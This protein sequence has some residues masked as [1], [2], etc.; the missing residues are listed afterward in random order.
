M[1]SYK[2]PYTPNAGKSPKYL[3]GRNDLLDRVQNQ[4]LAFSEGYNMQPIVYYGLRGVGKTVLLN[5]IEAVIEKHEN[6]ICHHIEIKESSNFIKSM[7]RACNSTASELSLQEAIKHIKNKLIS[8]INQFTLTWDVSAQTMSVG[9]TPNEANAITAD[10]SNDFTEILITL[11]KCAKETNNIIVF[12][13]DEIQYANTQ[14]LEAI[15]T[16]LHRV[17]QL[18]LPIMM[19]CAGLP[20]ILKTMGDVKSYAERL[21]QFISVGSLSKTEAIEAIENPARDIGVS[22]TKDALDYILDVTKGYPYFIQAVC[23]TIWENHDSNIIDKNAVMSYMNIANEALDSGFFAVRY[24]RAT[25]TERTFMIAMTQCEKTPCEI[26]AIAKIMNKKP[27]QI[28]PIRAQLIN[29]GL[30]YATRHGEI[31]FTAP[32][33]DMFIRR[34]NLE[35]FS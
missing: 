7:I 13:V 17:N 11:G 23:S 15:I 24:N 14:E 20:K 18:S 26:A 12:F 16:A 4:F 8:T 35:A 6:T 27:K 34:A 28:S 30:V 21:F 1:I 10:F 5:E 25:A 19:I 3:A 2:N 33:F 29:K 22:Y 9:V 32:Q 31:D